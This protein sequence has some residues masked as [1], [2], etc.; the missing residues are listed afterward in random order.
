MQI[1]GIY[2]FSL[3]KNFLR[4]MNE[5]HSGSCAD[6]WTPQGVKTLILPKITHQ[7]TLNEFGLKLE[8]QTFYLHKQ[9][10]NVKLLPKSH[11]ILIKLIMAR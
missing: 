4:G 6:F 1:C 11:T 3:M 7:I 8:C 5:N 9:M 10:S 2:Q